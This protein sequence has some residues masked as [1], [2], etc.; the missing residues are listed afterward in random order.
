M[1]KAIKEDWIEALRSGEYYKLK[2]QLVS[3][4]GSCNCVL[5]VLCEVMADDVI[6]VRDSHGFFVGYKDVGSPDTKYQSSTLPP[7]AFEKSGLGWTVTKMIHLND[8][9]K[10]SLSF[11]EMAD[12]IE[13]TL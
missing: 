3:R 8:R 9:K 7:K 2:N 10:N 6:A 12:Y 13:A 4:D 5:G 1:D 11:L